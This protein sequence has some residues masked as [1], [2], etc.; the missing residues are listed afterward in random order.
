MKL[1]AGLASG[2]NKFST[3]FRMTVTRNFKGSVVNLIVRGI[4]STGTS[5]IIV[6]IEYYLS[7]NL[8]NIIIISFAS[9]AVDETK[10]HIRGVF[11][12]SRIM[13]A[14]KRITTNLALFS[15]VHELEYDKLL[16]QT[17]D[18]TADSGVCGRTM[19]EAVTPRPSVTRG[20]G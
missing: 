7:N 2:R 1:G 9:K 15:G 17:A 20:V 5:G 6:N 18:P 13:L 3:W 14:L 11:S 4:I 16:S 19:G 12:S 10:E 8:P